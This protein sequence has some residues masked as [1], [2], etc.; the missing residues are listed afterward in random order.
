MVNDKYF[1]VDLG[2]VPVKVICGTHRNEME[3]SKEVRGFGHFCD[4]CTVKFYNMADPTHYRCIKCM[5]GGLD[6]CG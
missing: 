4:V 5:G 3:L 1:Y 2:R 6:I